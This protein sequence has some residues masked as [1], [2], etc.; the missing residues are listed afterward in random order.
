MTRKRTEGDVPRWIVVVLTLFATVA[1]VCAVQSAVLTGSPAAAHGPR[2]AWA[3][4]PTA[5][6][7]PALACRGHLP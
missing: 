5:S 1:A 3:T 2:T 7:P 4:P 6:F